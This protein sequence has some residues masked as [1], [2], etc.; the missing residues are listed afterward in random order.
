MK[1]KLNSRNNSNPVYLVTWCDNVTDIP[2]TSSGA[3]GFGERNHFRI[4]TANEDDFEYKT[5][6]RPH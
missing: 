1:F 6:I 2:G 4:L 5:V 3:I